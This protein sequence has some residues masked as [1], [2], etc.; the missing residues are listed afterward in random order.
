M[1]TSLKRIFFVGFLFV[2][3]CTLQAQTL[4]VFNQTAKMFYD[5]YRG[6]YD[7]QQYDLA[8]QPLKATP[9]CITLAN[10]RLASI[11]SWWR[12]RRARRP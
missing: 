2:F 12:L 11:L 9:L 5:Q 1:K 10:T 4:D 7:S 6:Y 3:T 8:I